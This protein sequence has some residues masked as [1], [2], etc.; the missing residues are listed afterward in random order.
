VSYLDKV[1]R[2]NR[3]QE[4]ELREH[5]STK[6]TNYTNKASQTVLT[7][8]EGLRN[9]P[10]GTLPCLPWQ[11]EA[12]LRAAASDALPKATVTLP[13]GL[14]PDLSRYTLAW[15]ASYLTGDRD[16]ALVRLWEAQRAWKGV[17]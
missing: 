3:R 4:T 8:P 1:K 7:P 15:A 6:E 9:N 11:L 16:E 12:L 5:P 10:P 13:A 2:L 17:N 14:V